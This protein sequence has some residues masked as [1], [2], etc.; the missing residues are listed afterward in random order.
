MNESWVAR[1]FVVKVKVR[2]RTTGWLT[3]ERRARKRERLLESE[4]MD[5]ACVL[6]RGMDGMAPEVGS[7]DGE[8]ERERVR[9]F[10]N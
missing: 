8:R 2:L 9:K 4:T 6:C 7:L 1:V 10:Q 3:G 5:G